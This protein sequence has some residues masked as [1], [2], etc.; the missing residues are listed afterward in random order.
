[1]DCLIEDVA[2]RER[3]MQLLNQDL[4]VKQSKI[5]SLSARVEGLSQKQKII[6]QLNLI[7]AEREKTIEEQRKLLPSSS[8]QR[9]NANIQ[10]NL[11]GSE[12]R[13]RTDIGKAL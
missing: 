2:S 11:T 4:S 9:R 5:E 10:V 3:H 7:L 12:E 6:D 13:L 8:K 1:V